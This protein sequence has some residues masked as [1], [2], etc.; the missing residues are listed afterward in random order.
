MTP[1]C[2]SAHKAASSSHPAEVWPLLLIL[3][4]TGHSASHLTMDHFVRLQSSQLCQVLCSCSSALR[5]LCEVTDADSK[6]S[7]LTLHLQET[8]S[9]Q[10]VMCSLLLAAGS[11]RFSDKA[12]PPQNQSYLTLSLTGTDHQVHKHVKHSPSE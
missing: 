3:V 1:D 9:R 7:F 8:Y 12:C 6:N 10:I 11:L 4:V 5:E 2:P